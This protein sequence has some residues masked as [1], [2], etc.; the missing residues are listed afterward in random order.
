MASIAIVT[1]SIACIT[2][3]QT[4]R[5]GI[6]IVP[7]NILFNGQ[8]YRDFLDISP[9]QAYE[10]LEK[11]PEF[12][13]SSAASPED[14]VKVYHELSEY[15][16]SILVVTISSKLSMFYTSA[17]TAKEIIREKLSHIEIDVLDS[18]TA[19]AAEGLIAL[20]AAQAAAEGRNFKEVIVTAK[21]VKERVG[22]VGLLETIRHVYR[23]GRIPRIA[24]EIGSILPV[25]P[26]LTSSSGAI[27]FSGAVSTKR[28]GIEIMLQIVKRHVGN[29]EI[30]HVAVMHA[31]AFEEAEELKERIAKEF[32]CVELFIT[33]FSPI[34]GYATGRGTLALAFY[35]GD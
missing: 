6:R 34:M 11:A 10:F 19:A 1:D 20:A 30:V 32:N 26:I 2:K 29:S 25:K 13:K 8:V 28:S 22:F 5:Y 27:H 21:K 14:Y 3:E 17:Q 24:S 18:G 12:W 23:T 15:V 35:R 31:D 9:A 4:E 16:Q 33:D 7:A